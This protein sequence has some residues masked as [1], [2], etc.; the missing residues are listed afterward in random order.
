MDTSKE[1][2]AFAEP[3]LAEA[4]TEASGG[5]SPASTTLSEASS[6]HLLSESLAA[7]NG[8][9]VQPQI[10]K[11][12]AETLP[13]TEAVEAEYAQPRGNADESVAKQVDD[14]AR[15]P[16]KASAIDPQLRQFDAV[17]VFDAMGKFK[18]W[19]PLTLEGLCGHP[20]NDG[21][22]CNSNAGKCS[23]HR[24][25]ELFLMAREDERAAIMERGVCGVPEAWEAHVSSPGASAASTRPVGTRNV[26]CAPCER[27]TTRLASLTAAAAAWCRG[28]RRR[29]RS[30]QDSLPPPRR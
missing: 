28:G 22:L 5:S 26:N 30:P 19:A 8:R 23:K 29:L 20:C 1:D 13:Q 25:R 17:E 14:H 2:K 24:Q 7:D 6:Q 21:K 3:A 11:T 16:P 4:S 18:H 15:R 10:G 9:E 12:V 27:R